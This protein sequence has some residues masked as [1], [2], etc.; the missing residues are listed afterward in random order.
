M[1]FDDQGSGRNFVGAKNLSA[2]DFAFAVETN[3]P[4]PDRVS[5]KGRD[6]GLSLPNGIAARQ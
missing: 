4:L 6:S 1:R 3:E 5:G 2:T